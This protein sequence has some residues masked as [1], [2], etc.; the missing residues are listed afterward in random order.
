M[1]Q[2]RRQTQLHPSSLNYSDIV[3]DSDQGDFGF[4]NQ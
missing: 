4:R 1:F 3:A 2:Q